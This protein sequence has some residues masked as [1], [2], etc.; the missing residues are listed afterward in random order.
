MLQGSN[1]G[2]ASLMPHPVIDARSVCLALGKG[3]A[4]VDILKGIDLSVGPGE[5]V[6]LLGPSGSGKSSLMAILSGLERADDGHVHVT[7]LDF[8]KLDEDALRWIGAIL[9]GRN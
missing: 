1:R 3:S 7:G 5:S 6:A 9:A 4:R 8:T 2:Q